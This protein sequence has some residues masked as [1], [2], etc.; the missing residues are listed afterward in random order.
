M[1]G[2]MGSNWQYK[3]K[4]SGYEIGVGSFIAG[5]CCAATA[6]MLDET[7]ACLVNRKG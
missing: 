3:D 2:M 4:D 6:R 7:C 1:M 5:G